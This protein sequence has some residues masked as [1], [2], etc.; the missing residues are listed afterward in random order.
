MY[1]MDE[2][3]KFTARCR[4]CRLAETRTTVVFGEGNEH[5][6]I[7]FVGEGPG[8]NEDVQGRPFV[9]KAGQLLDKM[10]EAINLKRSDVYIANVVKCRPPE[11]R[12]PMDDEAESC[13]DYL[14]WQVKLIRPKII[15]CLGAVSAKKLIDPNLSISRQRGVFVKKGDIFFMPTYHPSYLLRNESAKKDSWEDFKSIAAK[16]TKLKKEQNNQPI[17]GN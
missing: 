8:Y 9:G 6:D 11:N 5:A 15:V 13:I 1:S 3:K 16:L 12:N 14:R 2:L 10:I 7:M 4:K 17:G